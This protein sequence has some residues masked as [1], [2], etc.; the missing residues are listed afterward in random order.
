MKQSSLV[1]ILISKSLLETTLIGAIAVFFFIDSFPPYFH[2]WG[3]T[4]SHTIVGWAV[5]NANPWER[6]E[7]QLFIDGEFVASQRASLSR[8]DVLAAGWSR[9]EWHGFEFE[10]PSLAPGQHQ[11]QVYAVHVTANGNRR[12]LQLLGD[13]ITFLRNHDGTLTDLK[14]TTPALETR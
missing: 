10:V 2:G 5:N 7:I 9:D 11:A 14:K 12:T 1:N 8:P 3:E 6:V 13:P 4:T